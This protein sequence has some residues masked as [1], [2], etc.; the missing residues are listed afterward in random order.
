M[1]GFKAGIEMLRRDDDLGHFDGLAVFIANG[2]L[3]FGI[4][5]E[6]R[7][8]AAFA[9]F[10]HQS[11]NGVAVMDRSRHQAIRLTAGVT[12]HDA[13]VAGAFVLVVLGID[14]LGDMR[15]LRMQ[16]HFDFGVLPMKAFLLIADIADR[17]T[18][19]VHDDLGRN[20]LGAARFAGNDDTICR[21]QGF[22]RHAQILCR[23]A[24]LGPSRKKASTT[25]SE[26]R[27]QTLSGGLRKQIRW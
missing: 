6:Q 15:R 16:Q 27:S 23:P 14:A 19:G 20:V 22:A 24:I 7:F 2:D 9:R 18:G 10:G 21:R 11:E 17:L 26:I 1:D 3:R 5:S 4:G 12:E 13:L 25:S 8:A